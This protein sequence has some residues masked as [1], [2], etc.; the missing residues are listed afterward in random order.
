[1]I[2]KPAGDVRAVV[3]L[4]NIDLLSFLQEESPMESGR[5]CSLSIYKEMEQSGIRVISEGCRE[6][7][8]RSSFKERFSSI[9]LL[10]GVLATPSGIS[11]PAENCPAVSYDFLER[12]STD[13]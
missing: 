12:P 13:D 11:S 9:A 1:M 2:S 6:V 3:H 4:I 5:C 7:L 10:W 8:S